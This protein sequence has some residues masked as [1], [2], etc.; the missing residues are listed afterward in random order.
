MLKAGIDVWLDF[1]VPECDIHNPVA[2]KCWIDKAHLRVRWKLQCN[3]K[4]WRDMMETRIDNFED[5]RLT[6]KSLVEKVGVQ[7]QT[8]KSDPFNSS[9]RRIV[10]GPKLYFKSDGTRDSEPLH[11][12]GN[13]ALSSKINAPKQL[14][15]LE[16]DPDESMDLSALIEAHMP[17]II[18]RLFSNFVSKF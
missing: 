5:T 8:S 10:L 7:T 13:G 3:A 1:F 12:W 6:Q 9:L 11:Y 2:F 4:S 16:I 18:D 17:G 15:A 14:K